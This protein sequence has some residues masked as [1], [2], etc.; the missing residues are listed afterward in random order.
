MWCLSGKLPGGRKVGDN[1]YPFHLLST[2]NRNRPGLSGVTRSIVSPDEALKVPK[3]I[4]RSPD[5]DDPLVCSGSD[6][7]SIPTRGNTK[8][9]WFAEAS[10]QIEIRFGD[11]D[12]CVGSGSDLLHRIRPGP[13]EGD[14]TAD[15]L[16]LWFQSVVNFASGGKNQDYDNTNNGNC[17]H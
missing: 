12:L 8:G 2:S 13:Q 6:E 17:F 11:R 3:G 7:Y 16:L 5:C 4:L 9:Q 14:F 10:Y 15:A 1:I